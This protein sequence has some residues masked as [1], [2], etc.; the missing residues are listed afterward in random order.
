MTA[1]EKKLFFNLLV[2]VLIVLYLF[3]EGRGGNVMSRVGMV[4]FEMAIV[5]VFEGMYSSVVPV[6]HSFYCFLCSC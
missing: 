4:H 1:C 5:N 3:L 2:L 6:M